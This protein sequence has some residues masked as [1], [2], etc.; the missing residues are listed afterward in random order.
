MIKKVRNEPIKKSPKRGFVNSVIGNI[1]YE[2]INGIR[3]LI[4]LG[5]FP[6]SSMHT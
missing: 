6:F 4:S 2:K 5:S 1:T 3:R